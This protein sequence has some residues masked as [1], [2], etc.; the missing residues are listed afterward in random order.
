VKRIVL[1]IVL[2]LFPVLLF[3][4]SQEVD[5][6][7]DALIGTID[8]SEWDAWVEDEG[9]DADFTPSQFLREIAG[10][11]LRND[12]SG[13]AARLGALLLPG[14][15]SAVVRMTVFI[16][17]AVLIA[18]VNGMS[19]ASPIAETAKIALRIIGAGTVLIL[20]ASELRT[21]SG[22]VLKI[23][24]TAELLMPAV[25]G[26]LTLSGMEQTAALLSISYELLSGSVL[27]IFE[28][29][30]VPLAAIG[31]ILL[32]LDAGGTGR[33]AS[34]GK[35]LH[36]IAKWVLGTVCSLFLA[37]TAIRSVAAGSADGLLLKSTKLMAG[38]IPAVGGLL[39]E[40][41]DAAFQCL[42]LVKNALGLTG[43]V[44]I[45]LVA[46][47][48]VLSVFWTRCALRVS[49][50]LSEPLSGKPYAELLRGMGDT[51]HLLLLSELG[52]TAM[53]LLMIVPVFG[54]GRFV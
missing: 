23:T 52:A 32:A 10:M 3:T 30:V 24:R 20:S 54:P 45:L 43:T 17:F 36:R 42:Q 19:E 7:I 48:P 33:L 5:D 15:K 44:L 25:L 40:S 8:L 46:A 4:G 14:V 51:L 16:G 50:M 28:T 18:G 53:A 2:S 21:A 27:K 41:A 1:G 49:S 47:R 11:Q 38:S 29:C 37:F 26:F 9:I 6:G 34:I 13:L 31:G 39:S 35:V 22:T 12:S